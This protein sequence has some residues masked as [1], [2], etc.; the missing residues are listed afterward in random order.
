M[1]ESAPPNTMENEALENK[2]LTTHYHSVEF[3]IQ[4]VELPYQFKI[5]GHYGNRYH[6][7]PKGLKT[8]RLSA[9]VGI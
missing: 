7:L 6:E 5:D 3:S 1:K 9:Q 4:G 8:E 2:P